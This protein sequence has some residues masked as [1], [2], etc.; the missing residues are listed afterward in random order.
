MTSQTVAGRLVLDDRVAP[1]R[2]TVEHG[3][4]AAVDADVADVPVD[5]PYI[6]P[7]FVDVH[8]HG[9][10]GF[11]AMGDRAALDGM[12]RALLKRGVTSF[13]P[14]ALSALSLTICW[15]V[16]LRSPSCAFGK[17]VITR[18][19]TTRSSTASPRNSKR[20]LSSG[21]GS[22]CSLHHDGCRSACSSS[23]RS[24]NV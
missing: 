7:G 17:R 20:S 9:W 15:H 21:R 16:T 1:G 10:G 5:A 8:V 11:D 3:L 13:L 14:T 2:L 22:P 23:E 18:W 12:A 19:L 4:I 6:A 24:L